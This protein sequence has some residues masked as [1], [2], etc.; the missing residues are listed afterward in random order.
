MKVYGWKELNTYCY[1][2]LSYEEDEN[3]VKIKN[4]TTGEIETDNGRWFT[5]FKE[6]KRI[7]LR[8]LREKKEQYTIAIRDI[9]ETKEP[10]NMN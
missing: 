5:T 2:I 7:A 4:T 1:S 10:E 9:K 6:A 3:N 8:I